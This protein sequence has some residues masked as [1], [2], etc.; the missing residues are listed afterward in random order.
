[1]VISPFTWTDTK[2]APQT[3]T[4]LEL[5]TILELLKK[6]GMQREQLYTKVSIIASYA[7]EREARGRGY[8][9]LQAK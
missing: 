2:P 6:A 4:P 8:I 1:M 9:C 3:F 7:H 5:E